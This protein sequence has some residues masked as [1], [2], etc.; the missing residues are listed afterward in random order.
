MG[1][2]TQLRAAIRRD[3][4]DDP[5]A[6]RK[7]KAA[8]GR[9]LVHR[10][11]TRLLGATLVGAVVGAAL[12]TVGVLERPSVPDDEVTLA[13]TVSSVEREFR[14]SRRIGSWVELHTTEYTVDGRTYAL[15]TELPRRTAPEVGDPV[16]IG[17]S[18][19]DPSH[20]RYLDAWDRYFYW[21]FVGGG[22]ALLAVFGYVSLVTSAMFVVGSRLERGARRAP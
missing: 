12:L 9:R 7:A 10:A 2:L 13:A 14:P 20:A 21:A 3:W 4:P 16:T 15:T 19:A 6:G 8:T 11:R 5:E 18:Q 22:G 1:S 17:Y